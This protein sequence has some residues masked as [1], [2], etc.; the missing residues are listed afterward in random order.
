MV[1]LRR[2]SKV[3]IED[4]MIYGLAILVVILAIGALMYF[5]VLDLGSLL[6]DKCSI[7]S[8]ISCEN[9][10]VTPTSVKLQLKNNLGKNIEIS[11]I[12]IYGEQGT[13]MQGMW[14]DADGCKGAWAPGEGLFIN[15]EIKEFSF[16]ENCNVKIPF[17]KKA[18]G[19]IEL[20]YNIVGSEIKTTKFGDIRTSMGSVDCDVCSAFSPDNCDGIG[21]SEDLGLLP[22]GYRIHCNSQ[23]GVC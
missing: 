21:A 6:P 19:I 1:I 4:I 15:G 9:Y 20:T 8:E 23:C 10:G 14:S 17:D 5:G 7:G 2:K 13:D 22:I 11:S 12:K 3:V 16:R 18:D